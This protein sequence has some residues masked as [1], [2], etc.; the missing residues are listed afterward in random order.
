M[1]IHVSAAFLAFVLEVIL[2]LNER[3]IIERQ[4]VLWQSRENNLGKKA[5]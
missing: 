1:G 3:K 4:L 2:P 5:K